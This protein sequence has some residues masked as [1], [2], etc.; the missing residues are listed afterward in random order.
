MILE[1]SINFPGAMK[2]FTVN[3]DHK[4]PAVSEIIW[5]KLIDYHIKRRCGCIPSPKI[6]IY[7]LRSFP[8]KLPCIGEPCRFRHTKRKSS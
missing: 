1:A 6:V 4:G 2:S 5:Y 7:L 3:E 8:E